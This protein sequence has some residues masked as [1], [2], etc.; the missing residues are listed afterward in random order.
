LSQYPWAFSHVPGE[1]VEGHEV[2]HGILGAV[3]PL[4]LSFPQPFLCTGSQLECWID[5]ETGW[6]WKLA[7]T[8]TEGMLWELT[9]VRR[10]FSQ[11]LDTDP[12]TVP[13]LV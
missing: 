7:G 5:A 3:L 11:S 9:I 13:V 12:F 4:P 10:T 1:T 6:P 8:G 2:R